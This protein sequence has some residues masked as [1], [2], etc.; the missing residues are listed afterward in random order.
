M[1]YSIVKSSQTT[2]TFHCDSEIIDALIFVLEKLLKI[3]QHL[4]KK[5]RY[6]EAE[7]REEP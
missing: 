4:K 1:E 6:L 5:T 2:L 3:S 7:I